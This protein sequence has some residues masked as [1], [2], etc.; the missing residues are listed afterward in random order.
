VSPQIT[1]LGKSMKKSLTVAAVERIKPPAKGQKEHFDLG[2]PGLALRVSYAGSKSWTFYYRIA[3]HPRRMSLGTYPAVSLVEARDAWRAAR[4]AVAKGVDPSPRQ[5]ARAD[6]F[7]NVVAEWVKRDQADNKPA[8]VRTVEKIVAFDLLPK[9]SSRPVDGITKRD[10]IE[11]LDGI[12]DRGAPAKAR[13]VYAHLARFFK[14]CVGR[15]IIA[16]SPMTGIDKP[17]T[18]KT[19]ERVLTDTEIVKVWHACAAGPFGAAARLLLLT[20]ARR[21][22]ISSLSWSEVDSDTIRLEGE[23]TNSGKPR[24]IALSAPARTLLDAVPRGGK[25]VFSFDGGKAPINGWGHAKVRINAA[26]GI[27]D[28]RLH[29]L[30][31]TVA[32]GL[33]KLGIN[34]QTIEA[35]LGHVSGSRS[36]VVAIYQR[37][38][39]ADEARAALEAWGA[40]VIGLIEGRAPAKVLPIRGMR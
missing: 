35:V 31:R 32:T 2:F 6:T 22:E 8:S 28:W 40:H 18:V 36:G 38:E 4:V 30:R 24:T 37:H 17:D 29:D 16:A 11:L 19:R 12:M 26:A 39:F 9:W 14:W 1:F 13:S 34:L 5:S 7:A 21:E 25:Y 27:A 33:Q 20:G 10:V 15:D 23:R 3:G